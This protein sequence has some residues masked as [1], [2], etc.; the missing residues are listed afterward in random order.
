MQQTINCKFNIAENIYYL[1]ATLNIFERHF[2]T[3]IRDDT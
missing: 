2:L 1:S 3:I